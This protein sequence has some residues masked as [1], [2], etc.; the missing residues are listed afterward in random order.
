MISNDTLKDDNRSVGRCFYYL[1]DHLTRANRST[2]DPAVVARRR[3]LRKWIF[4]PAHRRQKRDFI[5]ILQQRAPLRIFLIHSRSHR[6][7]K[8]RKL[9]K[10][11]SVPRKQILH[12]RAF[13]QLGRIFR[14]ADNFLQTSKEKYAHSH[15]G[16][17][18][19][20]AARG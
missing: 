5:I 11:I 8:S 1:I 13:A 17:I 9:R 7:T 18:A 12:P 6:R 19:S 15:R 16:I 10:L 2:H 20:T 4:S 3:R 14:T